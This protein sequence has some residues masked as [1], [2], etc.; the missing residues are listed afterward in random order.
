MEETY[1]PVMGF[2]SYQVSS[3]GNVRGKWGV[4]RSYINNAGYPTVKLSVAGRSYSVRIHQ[5]VML[6]FIGPYPPGMEIRHLNGEKTDNRL[7]NL[8][9]GTRSEN[10]YDRVRHGTHHQSRKT[11]C[12]WGHPYDAANTYWRPDAGRGCKTCRADACTR[13]RGARHTVDA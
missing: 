2:E 9:Y 3:L 1:R 12:P 11:F 7:E 8:Q 4:L 13:R 10:M 5:A 6:A